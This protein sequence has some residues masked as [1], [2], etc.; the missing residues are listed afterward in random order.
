MK[1]GFIGI[2]DM[3]AAMAR[4]LIKSGHQVTVCNRSGSGFEEFKALGADATS[5]P[6]ETVH[7]DAVF[8]CLTNSQTVEAVFYGDNGLLNTMRKGQV[9]VDLGNENIAV[10]QTKI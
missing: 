5:N 6:A 8:M 4:N 1:I 7:G 2:G 3:G 9:L 10:V